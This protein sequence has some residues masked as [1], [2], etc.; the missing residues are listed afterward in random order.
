M[1][2]EEIIAQDQQYQENVR[3]TLNLDDMST[4]FRATYFYPFYKEK[5]Y[6]MLE[7]PRLLQ[8]KAPQNST[9]LRELYIHKDAI[10]FPWRPTN[11]RIT[12]N[13]VIIPSERQK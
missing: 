9:E 2:V 10:T 12:I 6:K 11:E 5:Q 8:A 3:N 13:E 7:I 4:K 1:V